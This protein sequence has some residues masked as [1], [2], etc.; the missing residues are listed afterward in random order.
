[1]T[2]SPASPAGFAG[3]LL[4][5]AGEGVLFRRPGPNRNVIQHRREPALDLGHGHAL[6]GG[7]FLHLVALDFR[8]PETMRFRMSEVMPDTDEAGPMAKLSVSLT[9]IARSAS[10]SRK[11]VVF[12]V[13]SGWAG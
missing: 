8:H 6:A 3:H 7:V 9:P 12:S 2:V 5:Q 4:P 11:S 10:G 1:M 13:W